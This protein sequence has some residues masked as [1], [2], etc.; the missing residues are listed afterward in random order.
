MKSRALLPN[1]QTLCASALQHWCSNRFDHFSTSPTMFAH[2]SFRQG[3]ETFKAA[4]LS[5]F[6]LLA[7]HTPA[8]SAAPMQP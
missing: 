6:V 7:L 1:A 8:P 3:A 2:P 4:A 5:A